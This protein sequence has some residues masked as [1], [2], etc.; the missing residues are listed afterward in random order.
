MLKPATAIAL[1][2]SLLTGCVTVVPDKHRMATK[3]P[4]QIVTENLVDSRLGTLRFYDGVP[5]EATAQKVFAQ[6]NF[7]PAI[8]AFL[9]GIPGASL[10]AMRRGL[11][12]VGAVDGTIGI[13]DELLDS[14]SLLLTGDPD[15]V[16]ATTWVDLT[17]GPVVIESP[18]NVPGALDDFWFRQVVDLGDAGPAKGQ[19]GKFVVLPPGYQGEVPPGYFVARSRTFNNRLVWRSVAVNGDPK[20][21]AQAIRQAARVYPLGDAAQ[22]HAPKFVALSGRDFSTV[23]ANDASFFTELNEVIQEEPA[24]ALAPDT[25]GLFNAAGLIKGQPFSPDGSMK[26]TLSDSALEGNAQARSFVFRHRVEGTRLYADAQWNT[27]LVGGGDPWLTSGG[28]RSLDARTRFFYAAAV[29]TPAMSV[30]T[31]GAG[32]QYA[33]SNLD[34]LGR[35]FDGEKTYRL[36]VPAKVPVKDFWSVALYDTQT[37]SLLQTDQRVPSLSGNA[38]PEAN[39]DGSVDVYFAPKRPDGAANWI[40]TVPGKSWFTIF[41]LHG[42]LQ[43]WFDKSWRLPDIDPI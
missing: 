30:A 35:P 14:K 43:P 1:A 6:P 36:R 19:G 5:S 12:E 42:P 10:V 9:N 18:P 41:W 38:G 27:P 8:D 28:A 15:S 32:T 37:R 25:M 2:C 16:Y 29:N 3:V 26:R 7:S 24:D 40:Q 34:L 33:S 11:R 4:K 39:A 21:A 22:P 20:P 31:T 17:K 13:W 23:H